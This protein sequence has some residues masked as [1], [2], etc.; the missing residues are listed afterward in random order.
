MSLTAANNARTLTAMSR[1][2][3]DV[4]GTAYTVSEL[5]DEGRIAYV[6]VRTMRDGKRAYGIILHDEIMDAH[7][8]QHDTLA[9]AL[10]SVSFYEVPMMVAT[11]LH[12]DGIS[13]VSF[14]SSEDAYAIEHIA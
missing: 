1:R 12:A 5:M 11:A 3:L 9:E 14:N 13:R 8:S 4:D 6:R 7:N 10:C 2:N